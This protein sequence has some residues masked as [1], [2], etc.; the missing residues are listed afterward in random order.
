MIIR[1]PF[2]RGILLREKDVDFMFTT[3][4]LEY[5]TKNILGIELYQIA[6]YL[7]GEINGDYDLNV[8]VLYGAYYYSCMRRFKKPKYKLSHAVVWYEYMSTSSR[9]QFTKAFVDLL[10]ELTVEKK[11]K[12][13]R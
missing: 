5:T 10:G 12:K 9:E 1:V 6:D 3:G 11:K 2:K 4:A 8:A 13:R 7:K